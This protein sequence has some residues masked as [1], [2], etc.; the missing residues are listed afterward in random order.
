MEGGS[1]TG[2]FEGKVWKKALK[3]GVSLR[4]GLL[5]NLGS[6]MTENFKRQL[7]GS[8]NGASLFAG[9]LLG[10]SFLGIWKDMGRKAQGTGITPWR[11]LFTGNSE[12]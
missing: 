11:G 2:D 6:P 1:F 5:G 7:E 4:R 9:A 3:T 8:R 12:R 10:G